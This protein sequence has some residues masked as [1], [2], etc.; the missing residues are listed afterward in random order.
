MTLRAEDNASLVEVD[1]STPMGELLRRYWHPVAASSQVEP[2]AARA[3]RLLGERLVLFRQPDG[4]L[5]LL[6]ERCPHRG[7]SL[8]YGMVGAD[9]I[10]CPYHGWLFDGDGRCVDQPN[11]NAEHGFAE[12]VRQPAYRVE[13]AGGLVFA[14]LGPAPGPALPL[15]DILT[16]EGV[17]RRI[18][19]AT[20]PVNWVQIAE[21]GLDPVHLE[22]L[23]GHLVN[24]LSRMR[25]GPDVYR[26]TKQEEISFDCTDLGIVKRRRVVGQSYDEEDWTVGQLILFPTAIYISNS[27]G[28]TVQY[29]VPVDRTT[30]WHVWYEVFDGEGHEPGEVAVSDAEVFRADGSFNLDTIDGQD[31]M[32]WIT[33]GEVA[34]R[35]RERL[36]EADKGITLFRRLLRE[37]SAAVASGTPPRWSDF[38]PAGKVIELPRRRS[39]RPVRMDV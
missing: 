18:R 23:H 39:G 3:V 22:W 37:Q 10:R 13:E 30:T 16:E 4:R 21:N 29:R 33:Q 11:E 14:Y 2:G 6:D 26:I 1:P 32:A 5:S 25:G 20:L 17:A 9:G 34:D 15:F 12:R 24:Y 27:T 28:R 31:V 8:A 38:G 7:A 19:T 35:T 36:G